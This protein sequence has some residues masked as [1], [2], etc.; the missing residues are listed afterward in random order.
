MSESSIGVS[1]KLKQEL[2]KLKKHEKESYEDV[3]WRILRK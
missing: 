3:L 1:R 2:I